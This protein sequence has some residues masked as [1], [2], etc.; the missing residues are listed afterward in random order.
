[1]QQ[2]LSILPIVNVKSKQGEENKKSPDKTGAFIISY[3]VVWG[4]PG[5]PYQARIRRTEAARRLT[6]LRQLPPVW[7]TLKSLMAG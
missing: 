5:M 6:E 7:R 1:M 4:F 2:L 3:S